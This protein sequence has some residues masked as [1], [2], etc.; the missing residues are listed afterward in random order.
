[1]SIIENATELTDLVQKLGNID[2]YRKIVELAVVPSDRWRAIP[3][4]S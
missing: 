2:L 1:M 4:F 3:S